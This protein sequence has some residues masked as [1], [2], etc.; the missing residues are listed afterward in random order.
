MIPP[1]P[2]FCK[3]NAHKVRKKAIF[4]ISISQNYYICKRKGKGGAYESS[5]F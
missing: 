2:S 1:H 4:R 5:K 3:K